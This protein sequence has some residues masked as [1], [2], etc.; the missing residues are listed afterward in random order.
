MNLNRALLDRFRLPLR[1]GRLPGQRAFVFIG[2]AVALLGL[3]I[4]CYRYFALGAY[5]DHIEGGVVISGWQYIHGWPLYLMQDGIP[6]S[7]TFYGPL[8]YL[9]EVPALA[10]LGP[11]VAATKLT[12]MLALAAT[13]GLLAVHFI[14][15][16]PRQAPQGLFFLTAGLLLFSPQSF[17]VRPDPFEL[18]LVALALVSA[19]GRWGGLWVGICIGLAVNFKVHAFVYFLPVLFEL[20]WARRWS[21]VVMAA[22]ASAATFVLPFLAPGISF[23]DY[24]TG[25]AHQVGGRP[26][27]LSQIGVTA[28]WFLVLAWPLAFPLLAS[29]GSP[30]DKAYAWCALTMLTLLIYPASFPGSGPY[31]FLP[32]VPVLADAY[33]R[34][35]PEDIGP[36]FAPFLMLLT[37]TVT[38]NAT[39]KMIDAQQGS[40]AVA[41]AALAMARD[42]DAQ[43]VQIG[44]G[45]NISSYKASQLSRT[46]LALNGY[47]PLIDGEVLMELQQISVDGSTRWVRYLTRCRVA[48]WLIPKG[49]K[50]FALV[51]SDHQ[52][53]LFGAAFRDAFLENYTIT[54][55]TKDFDVWGCDHGR[56]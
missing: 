53:P 36:E 25:L 44:Y 9:V 43:P 33:H 38:T 1:T 11:G 20:W 37:A 14:R 39:L 35:R 45:D 46:V 17:W 16:A 23:D 15:R 47:P 24:V 42:G 52:G 5:I 55:T 48:R 49:E 54:Q 21:A 32:L 18:L 34:L 19:Q 10:L 26:L 22:A 27:S 29:D 13:V 2:I 3:A 4:E 8:A 51:G 50:P 28:V 40:R 12:S 30:R 6:Q 7:S 31:H 41:D 56:K